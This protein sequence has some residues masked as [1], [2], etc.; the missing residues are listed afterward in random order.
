MTSEEARQQAQAEKLTL[1]VAETKTGYFGVSLDK[2]GR[3]KPYKARVR[4]CG[5]HVGL[6]YFAT[7]EEA[8]LCVARTPEGQAV[9]AERAAAAVPLTRKEARQQAQAEGLTLRL[10]ENKTGY[11]GVSLDKPG[12]PKPYKAQVWRDGKD[13]YLGSFATAEEAALCVARSPEGQAV[14]ATQ[15]A[16][17]AP[18]TSEEARQQ[19]QAEKL[20]LLVAETKTGYF[21]VVHHIPVGPSP[22]RRG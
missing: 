7:A 20:T 9:A 16:A 2:P 18:L 22:I 21:G 3:P 17:A 11:F 6:G 19:A 10:T 13:V 8:A 4:R 12:R 14:A 15:A 5:K 1:V